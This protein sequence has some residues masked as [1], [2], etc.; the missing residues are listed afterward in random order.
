MAEESQLRARRRER[1]TGILLPLRCALYVAGHSVHWV[2]ALGSGR[3]R[4]EHLPGL[5]RSLGQDGR[6]EVEL[7]GERVAL[8]THDPERLQEL[9][10]RWGPEVT[11][12]RR[13]ALLSLHSYL[14]S[15]APDECE[16]RECRFDVP[17]PAN[18]AT[19]A[20]RQLE[21]YG[22]FTRPVGPSGGAR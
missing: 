9:A 21:E 10:G 13:F 1:Q 14:V 12:H 3:R 16:W 8:R 2:Q 15:V 11:Y 5:L 18:S 17:P 19:A 4:E 7:A 20:A 22:G 6:L